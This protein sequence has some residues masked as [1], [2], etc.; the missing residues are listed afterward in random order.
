[1]KNLYKFLMFLAVFALWS[2]A[3]RA[4]PTCDNPLVIIQDDFES[5]QLGALGPQAD[6]WTTWSG[7]EGGD[8]DGN[9]VSNASASGV[10]SIFFQGQAGGGPQDVILSLGDRDSGMYFLSWYMLVAEGGKAYF[11][12]QRTTTPGEE[13]PVEVLFDVSSV[14]AL[15]LNNGQVLFTYPQ[16]EWFEVR[17]VIDTDN[18]VV[19]A[20]IGGDFVYTWPLTWTSTG[21]TSNIGPAFGAVDFYDVDENTFFWVDDVYFAEIPPAAPGQYCYMATPLDSA[22]VYTVDSVVCFG[23][24]FQTNSSITSGVAGAWYEW[25]A[26]DDGVL[27]LASCDGGADTRVWVFS[28]GCSALNLEGIN[29]DR[30]ELAPDDD[31]Y[32]S[33][34]QVLVTAGETYLICWDDRWDSNGFDF[35][36]G[37]TAG[38]AEDGNFCETAIAV[39]PN[40]TVTIDQINGDAAITGP[41][42]GTSSYNTPTAYSQSEWYAFTAPSDGMM[43]ISSCGLTGEDTRVWLYSGE[44]G[45]GGLDFMATDDDACDLQ[46]LIDSVE[47]TEGTTYYIEWSHKYT[48]DGF[49]PGFDWTLQFSPSVNTTEQELFEQAFGL[50]P[51]PASETVVLSFNLPA[52]ASLQIRLLDITG[53]EVYSTSTAQVRQGSVELRVSDLPQGLYM[54]TATDGQSIM[55]R[56]L[57]VQ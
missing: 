26:P 4:Q 41:I 7:N 12:L 17:F 18:D 42:I 57:I 51:N 30:C 24:G 5:Y 6:H 28:G 31:L 48:A 3:L 52:P 47:V 10:Q 39:E 35:E 27:T 56:K 23:A 54:V 25:T 46:S 9:V 8:E 36:L 1:M 53:K 14:G 44:C 11:N 20:F 45:F 2:G 34:R 32:A 22:G 33:Y 43:A 37:F 16:G 38:A 40:D 21:S 13:F 49:A 55:N 15:F 19:S 29:D 50:S